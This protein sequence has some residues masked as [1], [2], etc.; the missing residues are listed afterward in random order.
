[1]KL[2][3]LLILS[4][5]FLSSTI[6]LA[7][8]LPQYRVDCR[9]YGTKDNHPKFCYASAI[10]NINDNEILNIK[11]G[12]GCDYETIYNNGGTA[13]PQETV[14]DGIRP[15]TAATPKIELTPQNSL[16]NPGTYNSKIELSF[17]KLLDG[18]CYVSR[19]KHP[20]PYLTLD[21]MF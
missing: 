20:D 16:R 21:P 2:S 8:P 4:S 5:L 10:Y 7:D 19:V 18:V 11:Y 1:M 13:T 12:V 15:K 9:Y 14:S 6:S 17:E 3:S